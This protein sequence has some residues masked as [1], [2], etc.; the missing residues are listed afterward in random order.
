[1]DTG[2]KGVVAQEFIPKRDAFTSLMQAVKVC[3]V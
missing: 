1:V 2:F 3:D